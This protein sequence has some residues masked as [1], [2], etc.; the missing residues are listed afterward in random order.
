MSIEQN[1][2][3]LAEDNEYN[4]LIK[5]HICS[6][7]NSVADPDPFLVLSDPEPRIWSLKIGS[8]TGT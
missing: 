8:G 5:D 2:G 4:R 1:I 6:L 3:T 7:N